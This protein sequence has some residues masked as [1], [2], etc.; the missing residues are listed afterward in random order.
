[1]LTGLPGLGRAAV[2]PLLLVLT[3]L[4]SEEEG[5]L[6]DA[7]EA[8]DIALREKRLGWLLERRE[9][10]MA[11]LR[12]DVEALSKATPGA[13]MLEPLEAALKLVAP[14]NTPRELRR[15]V[16]ERSVIYLGRRRSS[17]SSPRVRGERPCESA[18]PSPCERPLQST[19]DTFP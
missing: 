19:S 5:S 18:D 14:P 7:V 12:E 1:M 6:R 8:H 17:S 16:E 15:R 10:E 4:R 3:V 9:Q 11:G 13:D 2:D